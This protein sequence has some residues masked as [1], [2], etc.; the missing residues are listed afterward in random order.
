MPFVSFLSSSSASP[1]RSTTTVQTCTRSQW[2]P[3]SAPVSH[4]RESG[5]LTDSA[6]NTSC[7]ADFANHAIRST[8][9]SII[10]L[11]PQTTTQTSGA[12]TT[13]MQEQC[14]TPKHQIKQQPQS[15]SKV[16]FL[17]G[18]TSSRETGAGHVSSP[19]RVRPRLCFNN[20]FQKKILERKVDS[21]IQ[22]EKEAQLKLCEAAETE[23][24]KWDK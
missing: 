7:G 24:K 18:H 11:T 3:S 15:R 20:A 4:W 2:L 5:R 6:P 21:A 1:S 22:G 19:G 8:I 17:L 10:W 16:S 12:Q 9:C 14:R 23:A 13:S